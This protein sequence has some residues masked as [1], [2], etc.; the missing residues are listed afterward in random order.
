MSLISLLRLNRPE[1][2][3]IIPNKCATDPIYAGDVLA[4]IVLGLELKYGKQ[5]NPVRYQ[6][7]DKPDGML[8]LSI[9]YQNSDLHVQINY[10]FDKRLAENTFTHD[11]NGPVFVTH[12]REDLKPCTTGNPQT[13]Q[14]H[15]E[16]LQMRHITMLYFLSKLEA[17]LL[18][19]TTPR[20]TLHATYRASMTVR[21]KNNRRQELGRYIISFPLNADDG[22]Q[23]SRILPPKAMARKSIRDQLTYLETQH[24]EQIGKDFHSAIQAQHASLNSFLGMYN[25]KLP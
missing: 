3:L 24:I 5:L 11:P 22:K 4:S 16:S 14:T 15:I 23:I 10:N 21:T 2:S 25:R 20:R 6:L 7:T 19:G 12:L 8:K 1:D 13:R 9:Y 17:M 18:D